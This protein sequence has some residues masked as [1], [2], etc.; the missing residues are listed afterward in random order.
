MM[1]E[2]QASAAGSADPEAT[3]PLVPLTAADL[4]R[5]PERRDLVQMLDVRMREPSKFSLEQ[6]LALAA[7]FSSQ[8]SPEVFKLE[9]EE[10]MRKAKS[11]E[12]HLSLATYFFVQKAGNLLQQELENL[13][14]S[15]ETLAQHQQLADA[16]AEFNKVDQALVEWKVTM[17]LIEASPPRA[18][19][20]YDAFL[21]ASDFVWDPALAQILTMKDWERTMKLRARLLAE[22]PIS[23]EVFSLMY[24]ETFRAYEEEKWA[25]S[26]NAPAFL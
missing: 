8:G 6:H 7:S 25:R 3:L 11:F 1:R 23:E 4:Q 19:S 21:W 24:I 15:V 17:D 22:Y 5:L 9:T 12:Q 2:W 26:E 20:L 16:L 10:A 14:R 13:R 18:D